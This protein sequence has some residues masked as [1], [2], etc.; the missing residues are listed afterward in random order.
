M[1][2]C[3]KSL[4]FLLILLRG[5]NL[6]A[7]PIDIQ[8]VHPLNWYVGM[9]NPNLQ[10]LIYGKNI[11]ASKVSLTTY[12]GV[13]LQSVTRAENPN[14]LF[15]DLTIAKTAQAGTLQFVF[16]QN[17]SHEKRTSR[18]GFTMLRPTGFSAF[19]S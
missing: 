14:Y 17:G 10:I 9:L 2:E 12:A 19:P 8:K 11:A 1:N 13:T 18:Q 3:M 5:V 15:V 4:F 6:L 7:Q 16:S